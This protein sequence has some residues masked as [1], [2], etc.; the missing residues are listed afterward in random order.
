MQISRYE[1]KETNFLFLIRNSRSF[2]KIAWE[3]YPLEDLPW[4]WRKSNS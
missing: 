1:T 3:V 2:Q 4:A